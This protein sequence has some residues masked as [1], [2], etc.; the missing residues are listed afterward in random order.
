MLAGRDV[1]EWSWDQ[2]GA[3]PFVRHQRAEVAGV[4]FE[5]SSSGGSNASERLLSFADLRF[6]QPV[7]ASTLVIRAVLPTGELAILGGGVVDRQG[8]IQQLFGRS[9]SKYRPLYA[10]GEMRVYENT[11]AMPRAFLV[12]HARIAPSIG[13]SLAEMIHRPF[14]PRHEVVV[15]ADTAPEVTAR[16]GSVPSGGTPGTAEVVEHTA[17][18]VR[19]HTSSTGDAL[20]VLTDTYY[21]G[22]RAEVDGVEQ[23]LVR[24]DL[25][26]RVVPVPGG[27]HDVELRFEPSSVRLGLLISLLALLLAVA[28][29]AFAGRSWLRGRTT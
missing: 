5:G 6:D 14:D 23:P 9:R 29:L 27:E 18:R 15:A 1:M 26:F 11:A 2:P 12:D 3:R 7:A 19:V 10:D 16:L 21:P 28:G 8:S 17:N 13:A 4:V 24:G 20:L 25:L 22:W